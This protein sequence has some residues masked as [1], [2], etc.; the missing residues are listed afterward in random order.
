MD[1]Q[2][3]RNIA[4]VKERIAAAA[5]R[6]GRKAEDIT[7]VAVTK[8]VP[9]DRIR[10]AIALGIQDI[11]E[12]RVQEAREKFPQIPESVRWHMVGHLQRNKV[13]YAVQM[14]DMIQSVDSLP[15]A[16][17][18]EKRAEKV[19]RRLPVLIEVNTSGESSK[20][21]VAPSQAIELAKEID[22]LSHLQ[23]RGFMTIAIL[24]TDKTR[25]RDCFKRL[26]HIYEEARQMSWQNARIDTL[27][28]GMTQDFEEAIE[29]GATMVRLGTAIFG[30]RPTP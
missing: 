1:E 9:V 7:L 5:E 28:M 29:E 27:S 19:R 20:Y 30:P 18:L 24:S 6:S 13:K 3:A 8:T 21:G 22:G 23:L 2:L 10:Q 17:E 12:N 14:F 15:L 16:L 25:V 26:R 11:G 4:W